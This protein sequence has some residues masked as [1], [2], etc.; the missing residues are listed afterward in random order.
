MKTFKKDL[1]SHEIIDI[2]L[3]D[4]IIAYPTDTVYGLGAHYMSE[5]A[6][7]RI[8]R[9]KGRP[10]Q[11]GLPLL[12]SCV[13][14]ADFLAAEKP[15]EMLVLAQA[16]WPGALTLV[17]KARPEIPVEITGTT[18]TVAVRV[19]DHPIPRGLVA[20]LGAPIIGTSANLSGG[21]DPVT[22]VDVQSMLGDKIDCILDGGPTVQGEP[23]TVLDLTGSVPK[24]VRVGAIGLLE[25][26]SVVGYRF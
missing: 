8:Y 21:P 20:K 7:K 19:P 23:S 24:V 22:A 17:L 11:K 18:K 10:S 13:E 2:L 4:G 25:L 15:K 3:H 5:K 12:L 14:D 1:L 9:V 6:V 16:F 26:Q